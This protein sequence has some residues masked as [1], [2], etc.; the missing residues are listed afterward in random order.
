MCE[1]AEVRITSEGIGGPRT[2][3]RPPKRS[4]LTSGGVQDRW[5]KRTLAKLPQYPPPQLPSVSHTSAVCDCVKTPKT[6]PRSCAGRSSLSDNSN[7][8]PVG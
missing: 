6:H 1:F 8:R 3:K 7:P 5:T 4:S 2:S